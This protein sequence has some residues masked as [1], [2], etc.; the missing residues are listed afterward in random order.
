MTKYCPKCMAETER[1]PSGGCKPCVT[2]RSESWRAANHEKL[3]L[4]RAAYRKANRERENAYTEMYRKA[5]P[6]R[7]K[8]RRIAW[9]KANKEKAK[10]IWASWRKANP[11]KVNAREVA[12]RAEM[13]DPYIKMLIRVAVGLPKQGQIPTEMIEAKRTELKLKR[14]IKEMKK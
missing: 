10:V 8:A 13:R 9:C 4:H 1:Y 12:Y 14:L 7:E 5:N 2:A 3:K 11:E 6:E